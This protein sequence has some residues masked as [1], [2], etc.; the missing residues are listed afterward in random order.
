MVVHRYITFSISLVGKASLS[1][2]RRDTVIGISS[3]SLVFHFRPYPRHDQTEN[4]Y[5]EKSELHSVPL[6]RETSTDDLSTC[7]LYLKPFSFPAGLH[8]FR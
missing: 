1:G 4:E 7:V 6:H 2:A 3:I 5:L 8:L